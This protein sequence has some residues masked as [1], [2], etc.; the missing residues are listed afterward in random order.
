VNI[1]FDAMY[2]LDALLYGMVW[3]RSQ[4][5]K[6]TFEIV[7]PVFRFPGDYGDL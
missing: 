4:Q 6:D 7:V 3:M 2:C 5:D 1:A